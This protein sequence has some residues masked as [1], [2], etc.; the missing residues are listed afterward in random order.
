MNKARIGIGGAV[1]RAFQ[2]WLEAGHRIPVPVASPPPRPSPLLVSKEGEGGGQ[3][4]WRRRHPA[5]QPVPSPLEG[6][7]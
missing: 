2:V 6:E 1:S 7:G 4:V 3:L 5:H